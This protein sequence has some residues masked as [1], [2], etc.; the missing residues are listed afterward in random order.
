M[1]L[2]VKPF[3]IM[4]SVLLGGVAIAT[5][6]P[7]VFKNGDL[8]L[9]F[10]ATGG[11]GASQNVFFNLGSGTS[12]RDKANLGKLGNVGAT[13]SAVYGFDWYSRE[14]VYFGVVGNL[15]N[16]DPGGIF[17][18]KPVNGDPSRTFYISRP[19]TSP[20]RAD[21]IPAA[22]Y[23]SA[24]LGSAGTKL[25]G[26][27]Q[28]LLGTPA[29]SGLK[30]ESDDSAIL[31]QTSQSVQWNNS[32]TVWNPVPGATLDTFAGG[33][34]QNF[35]KGGA[36]TYVDIQRILPTATGANPTGVVGGST[37]ETSIAITSTGLISAQTTAVSKKPEI[38]VQQPTGTGLSDGKA[39]KT[40]A[41]VVVGKAGTPKTFTIKNTGTGKLTGLAITKNGAQP[42]SFAVSDLSKTSLAPGDSVTFK[43]TFKPTVKGTN[44]AAIHIKSNDSNENPFDI[45]LTGSGVAPK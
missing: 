30:A 12:H 16:G 35:G 42:K 8:I 3:L 7:F 5:A 21:L 6:A 1:K 25:G 31:D 11:T 10:Q 24:S 26:M 22:S 14:D 33:V 32:W 23:P 44:N 19:T 34:Q 15:N 41:N 45:E 38:V 39:K 29:V 43:V 20:G 28:M 37:Y 13:L 18:V 2:L 40:F 36:A 17:S 27:E 4:S 9:G